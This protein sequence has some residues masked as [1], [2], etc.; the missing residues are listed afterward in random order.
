MTSNNQ[1]LQKNR[2]FDFYWKLAYYRVTAHGI[3][4]QIKVS[5]RAVWYE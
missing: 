3:P 5:D 4:F 2:F 1:D